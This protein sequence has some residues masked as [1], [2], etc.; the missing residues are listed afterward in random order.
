MAWYSMC[1]IEHREATKIPV[2]IQKMAQPDP[3]QHYHGL[4]SLRELHS[5][6]KKET[7]GI[8]RAKLKLCIVEACE[9]RLI[10]LRR[11]NWLAHFLLVLL[12]LNFFGFLLYYAP[13]FQY[14]VCAV[15]L[16][17]TLGYGLLV[18]LPRLLYRRLYA[19]FTGQ[20]HCAL[21]DV[22]YGEWDLLRIVLLPVHFVS[23]LRLSDEHVSKGIDDFMKTRKA[24]AGEYARTMTWQHVAYCIVLS[25]TDM[26][27]QRV[28]RNHLLT[29]GMTGG[30]TAG[31]ST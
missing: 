8:Y 22:Q 19:E 18:S 31:S 9:Q 7:S 16:S 14:K 3:Q 13:G 28:V 26:C 1:M 4:C 6:Y 21:D 23:G 15:C 12:W 24:N 5:R 11:G 27:L 20:T 30:E 29:T 2:Q 17:A 10:Y 25:V